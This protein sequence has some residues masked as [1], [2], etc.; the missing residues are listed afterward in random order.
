[1]TLLDVDGHVLGSATVFGDKVN[2]DELTQFRFD[3]P[4]AIE[5]DA[6]Y[7]VQITAN[8]NHLFGI[9]IGVQERPTYRYYN[10]LTQDYSDS[11]LVYCGETQPNRK[12]L[13]MEIYGDH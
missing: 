7:R 3:A 2:E 12:G 9:V 11:R 13:V 8:E 4:I 5:K 6:I 10:V 1:M